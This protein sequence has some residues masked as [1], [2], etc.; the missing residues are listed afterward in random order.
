MLPYPPI[1][2]SFR[3]GRES[4]RWQ[5]ATEAELRQLERNWIEYK[6]GRRGHGAGFDSSM[7]LSISRW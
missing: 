3:A 6:V 7:R 4:G 1:Q 2:Q 5:G